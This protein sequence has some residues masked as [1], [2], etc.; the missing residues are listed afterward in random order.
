MLNKVMD[1]RIVENIG[2]R[3]L[4]Y[5]N[6]NKPGKECKR[7]AFVCAFQWHVDVFLEVR[8]VRI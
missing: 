8:L 4:V 3:Y 5:M 1:G 6:A 2:R 7:F